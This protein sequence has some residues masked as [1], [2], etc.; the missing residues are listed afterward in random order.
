[1]NSDGSETVQVRADARRNRASIVRAAQ[2]LFATH[3]IEVGIPTIAAEAGIAVGTIYR[4]YPSKEHLIEAL[5]VERLESIIAVAEQVLRDEGG[6]LFA[7]FFRAVAALCIEDGRFAATVSEFARTSPAGQRADRQLQAVLG[8]LLTA[9]YARGELRMPLEPADI[10][11]LLAGVRRA[12]QEQE[13]ARWE[14]YIAIVLQ[15]VQQPL[16]G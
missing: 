5:V 6:Q 7:T 16:P 8:R 3:G 13:P 2:T 10:P 9:A 14:R 1:M 4:H 11:I 12:V 15:G